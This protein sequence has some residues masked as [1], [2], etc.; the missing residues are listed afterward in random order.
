[1]CFRDEV[2]RGSNTGERVA[3]ATEILKY[4]TG[5]NII[6]LAATHDIELTYLLEDDYDNHFFR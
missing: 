1:M 2:L 4:L 5:E 6:T 3:A